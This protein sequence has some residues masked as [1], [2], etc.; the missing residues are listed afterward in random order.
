MLST[1]ATARSSFINPRRQ[2]SKDSS[3]DAFLHPYLMIVG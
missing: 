3:G 2:S 1:E